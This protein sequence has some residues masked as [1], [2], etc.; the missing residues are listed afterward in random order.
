M[1]DRQTR[2]V[3]PFE[4]GTPAGD[5]GYETLARILHMKNSVDERTGR[6]AGG[7]IR[8]ITVSLIG[9]AALAA[10]LVLLRQGGI[11]PAPETPSVEEVPPG[12]EV[13]GQIRLERLRELGI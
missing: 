13:P 2:M 12:E 8:K 6:N 3:T 7:V 5:A 4:A 10:G 9:T 11:R 1:A